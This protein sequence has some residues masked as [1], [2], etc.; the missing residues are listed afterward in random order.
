[1]CDVQQ[2]TETVPGTFLVAGEVGGLPEFDVF[3]QLLVGVGES[4]FSG[5]G[6]MGDDG[7]GVNREGGGG[8]EGISP[9]FMCSFPWYVALTERIEALG[10]F[11]LPI[12][13][14]ASA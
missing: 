12:P 11:R 5:G 8:E 3:R 7:V 14:S 1:M 9:S 10:A 13:V 2:D 4:L 6:G